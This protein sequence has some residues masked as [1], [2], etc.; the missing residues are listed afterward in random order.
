MNLLRFLKGSD[1]TKKSA[2]SFNRISQLL[3]QIIA[4]LI[5][6]WKAEIIIY[7]ST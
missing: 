2:L 5:H 7:L 4:R 3:L 6:H 1:Q